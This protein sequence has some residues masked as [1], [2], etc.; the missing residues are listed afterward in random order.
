MSPP[1]RRFAVLCSGPYPKRWEMEIAAALARSGLAAPTAI[2]IAPRSPPRTLVER[3]WRARSERWAA[4]FAP[5]DPAVVAPAVPVVALSETLTPSLAVGGVDFVIDFSPAGVGDSAM[6]SAPLGRWFLRIGGQSSRGADIGTLTAFCSRESAV[7]VELVRSD[8]ESNEQVLYDGRF[9]RRQTFIKTLDSVLFGIAGWYVVAARKIAAG[10]AGIR[11]GSP[12]EPAAP[13]ALSALAVHARRWFDAQRTRYT[14]EIWNIGLAPRPAI[15]TLALGGVMR[16]VAWMSD[17]PVLTFRADPFGWTDGNGETWVAHERFDYRT[18]KGVLDL[19]RFKGAFAGLSIEVLADLP[20]HASYP[21]LLLAQGQLLCLPEVNESGQTLMFTIETSPARLKPALT[22]LKDVPMSDGTIFQ[23]GEH[24]WLF[25]TRADADSQLR[26]FAWFATSLSGPW[27]PHLL[28]PIK[29]DITSARPAGTPFWAG[30]SLIR[31]AQDCSRS[32]GS[33]ITL[34][35]IVALTPTEFHEETVG[36]IEPDPDGP[37]PDGI[38]TLSFVG[39]SV[40]VDGK[41]HEF[42]WNAARL[43]RNFMIQRYLRKQR[44]K[45]QVQTAGSS[46]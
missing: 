31:P 15:E 12:A 33:A 22:L 24:L 2:W 27:T 20:V 34:N 38:H 36:R 8:G 9:A 43:N 46:S 21:F 26:L 5:I 23:F 37:Y 32:Y 42:R 16:D 7:Q 4:S 40:L 29:C 41:R 6:R 28:N 10:Q 39:E 18:G 44:L 11:R 3:F 25:G 45:T 13:S 17:P 14:L 1:I 35:R 30:G 19:A